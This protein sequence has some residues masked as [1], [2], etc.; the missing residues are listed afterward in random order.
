M[1]LSEGP[2]RRSQL[3]FTPVSKVYFLQPGPC[4]GW[5][6]RAHRELDV[7]QGWVGYTY[8]RGIYGRVGR[9]VGIPG[10]V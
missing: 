10:W 9:W 1:T 4:T 5:S 2:K 3:L 7:E 6:H 8:K